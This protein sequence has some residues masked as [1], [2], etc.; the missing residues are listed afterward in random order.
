MSHGVAM[1]TAGLFGA[2]AL[3]VGGTLGIAAAQ[4]PTLLNDILLT[5]GLGNGTA[6][7]MGPGGSPE[8]G[9]TYMASIDRLY[10]EP[11]GFT[12]DTVPVT[13]SWTD[14]LGN[15]DSRVGSEADS[16]YA[17][18]T[19]QLESGNFD[20]ENPLVVVGY[21]E[22]AVAAGQ[23]MQ[24]LADA[25]VPTEDLHFVLLGDTASSVGGFLNTFVESLPESLQD[26]ARQM[27][28]WFGVKDL[29][30]ATTP[31]DLYP[32]TV[33]TIPGDMWGD[34]SSVTSLQEAINGFFVHMG[35]IGLTPEQI[36]DATFSHTEGLT[37]FYTISDAD[38]NPLSAVWSALVNMGSI[39][40]WL[41]DMVS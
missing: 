39:P 32:T 40:E 4:P 2:V 17:A 11:L 1:T 7:I 20:A 23:V 31:T 35:Y 24:R 27:L 14:L 5:S 9:D 21:S 26:V 28:G 22:S 33:Y 18:I 16:L 10:L 3:T 12:G 34:W 15:W 13:Y 41:A 25:N 38:M 30:D 36:D 6:L 37:D 29:L 19:A 8:P